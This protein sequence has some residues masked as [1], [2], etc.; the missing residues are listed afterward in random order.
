MRTAVVIFGEGL[1]IHGPD[2]AF[3]SIHRNALNPAMQ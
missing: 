1:A 2:R 3:N